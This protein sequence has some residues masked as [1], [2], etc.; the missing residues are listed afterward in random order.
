MPQQTTLLAKSCARSATDAAIRADDAIAILRVVLLA[1][2]GEAAPLSE[3]NWDGLRGSI[4]L[5]LDN[6]LETRDFALEIVAEAEQ[7]G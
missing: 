2:R 3:F 4:G 7:H 1:M 6:V 5:A